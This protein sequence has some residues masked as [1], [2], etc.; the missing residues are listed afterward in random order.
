MTA[1]VSSAANDRRVG[2]I[3]L[4]MNFEDF[5]VLG[6]CRKLQAVGDFADLD[7]VF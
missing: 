4:L 1:S 6:L 7:A 2:G 3:W 5:V